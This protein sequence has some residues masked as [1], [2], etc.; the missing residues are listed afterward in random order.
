[1]SEEFTKLN[2]RLV[3]EDFVNLTTV[4]CANCS[5]TFS[6]PTVFEKKRREDHTTFQCPAGH[7]NFYPP[8]PQPRDEE[9]EELRETVKQLRS[10]L[11]A[12]QKK[13]AAERDEHERTR[14]QRRGWFR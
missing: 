4:I 14:R 12:I 11:R 8:T 6:I 1:M 2:D 9:I 13:L 10:E 5:M 7:G 3:R